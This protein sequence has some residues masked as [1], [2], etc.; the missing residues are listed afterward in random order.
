L[1]RA[2]WILLFENILEIKPGIGG[3][4]ES[5]K[6]PLRKPARFTFPDGS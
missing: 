1:H 4:Q 2:H 3:R 5:A 6:S